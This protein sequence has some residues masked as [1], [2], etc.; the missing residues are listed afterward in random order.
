MT[1]SSQQ[2]LPAAP[3][4]LVTL[5]FT[6]GTGRKRKRHRHCSRVF[7]L[8]SRVSSNLFPTFRRWRL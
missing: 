2:L 6:I 1:K 3:Q 8:C 7:Q 4:V 5:R